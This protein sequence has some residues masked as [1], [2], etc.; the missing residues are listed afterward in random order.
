MA[1]RLEPTL[2]V[3]HHETYVAAGWS[4]TSLWHM[5]LSSARMSPSLRRGLQS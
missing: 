1:K 2:A 3:K 5:G 4:P